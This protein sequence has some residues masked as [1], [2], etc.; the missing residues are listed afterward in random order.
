MMDWNYSCWNGLPS[1]SLEI[2]LYLPTCSILLRLQLLRIHIV[3]A[4][5][6]EFLHRLHRRDTVNCELLAH[7]RNFQIYTFVA[8]QRMSFGT[9]FIPPERRLNS[10]LGEL[11]KRMIDEDIRSNIHPPDPILQQLSQRVGRRYAT[12]S[13]DPK[14]LSQVKQYEQ[15]YL[16]P[17]KSTSKKTTSTADDLADVLDILGDTPLT[18]SSNVWTHS[19]HL[20]RKVGGSYNGSSIRADEPAETVTSRIPKEKFVHKVRHHPMDPTNV[21][22]LTKRKPGGKHSFSDYCPY[23]ESFQV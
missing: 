14:V 2:S 10:N 19:E 7:A 22:N 17:K 11:Q 5:H 4:R 8:T 21:I 16:S 3:G 6:V 15:A 18:T 20:S 23:E 12:G 1:F 9:L 13:D